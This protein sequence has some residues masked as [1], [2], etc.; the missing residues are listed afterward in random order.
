MGKKRKHHLDHPPRRP[1]GSYVYDYP[2]TGEDGARYPGFHYKK[3]PVASNSQS[4]SSADQANNANNILATKFSLLEHMLTM[5]LK[6]PATD[7]EW[8]EALGPGGKQKADFIH[9]LKVLQES[10]GL[11]WINSEPAVVSM[12]ETATHF[13]TAGTSATPSSTVLQ[14]SPGKKWPPLLPQ[15]ASPALTAQVFTHP[16][17][18]SAQALTLSTASSASNYNRLEFLGD[19]VLH[20]ILTKHLFHRFPTHRENVL[21]GLRAEIECNQNLHKYCITY[22]LNQLVRIGKDAQNTGTEKQVKFC[23]DVFE[24]Y[25]GALVLDDPTPSGW[26]RVE[27]WLV[28]LVDPKVQ[29]GENKAEN[30]V[31]DRGSK[32]KLYLLVAGAKNVQLEYL[33]EGGGGMNQGGY[34]MTCY[35]TGFGYDKLRLGR[36]WGNNKGDAQ[37]KAAMNALEDEELIMTVRKKKDEHLTEMGY[38]KKRKSEAAVESAAAA[39]PSREPECCAIKLEPCAE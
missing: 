7:A 32:Q 21:S 2:G 14:T 33:W 19:A 37:L 26:E 15:I 12:A 35:L 25:L 4:A 17:H 6:H 8:R 27:Q 3:E 31:V 29:V 24:A 22:G 18:S 9:T 11:G 36:G 13:N 16:S 23:A 39:T 38:R 20:Y 28:D 30:Y 10:G 1:A 34:W 5:V